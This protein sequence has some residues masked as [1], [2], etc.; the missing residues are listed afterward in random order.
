M[1]MVNQTS[2]VAERIVL[3]DK[4]GRDI[5]VVIVKCTYSIEGKGHLVPA[6]VQVPIQMADDF[7]GEPGESS[8]R[9]E[10]DLALKKVGTDI[11]L[12]GHAYSQGSKSPH[13]DVSLKVGALQSTVRVFGDRRWDKVLGITRISSPEP[14]ERIPLVY[15]RAYGGKDLSSPDSKHHEHE[16]RNPVG[17]GF[18][19]KKSKQEIEGMLIPNLEDPA[20]LIRDIDHRPEPVG[21]GFIGRH[22]QP[23]MSFAGTYDEAWMKNRC[24]LLPDDFDDRYFNGAHPKLVSRQYLQGNEPVEVLNASVK[25]MLRFSLPG[26][27]PDVVVTIAEEDNSLQMNFD[28]LIIEPD[29]KRVMMVWRGTMDIYNRLYQVKKIEVMAHG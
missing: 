14:F 1:E 19:A 6:E 15:E 11:V 2:F 3:Q 8:V 27:R 16:A 26:D 21:F 29:E 12:L 24:P 9:Y 7:Y 5:L 13:V 10:S 4:S 22:W 17:R 23:R 18:R 28:T 25:G 20:H